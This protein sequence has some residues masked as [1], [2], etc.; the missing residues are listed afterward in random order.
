MNEGGFWDG[1]NVR[2]N[3][4]TV[5]AKS[6]RE[7]QFGVLIDA[8]VEGKTLMA[9]VAAADKRDS[10]TTAVV[11]AV[12]KF[13]T[14]SSSTASSRS[15]ESSPVRVVFRVTPD[16]TETVMGGTADFRM[17]LRNTSDMTL[18][19]LTVRMTYDATK[20]ILEDGP[21]PDRASSNWLEWDIASLVRDGSWQATVTLR[22]RDGVSGPDALTVDASIVGGGSMRIASGSRTA[23]AAVGTLGALPTTGWGLDAFAM[24]AAGAA[25][26]GLAAIQR[27]FQ[28]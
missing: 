8:N 10:D 9:G 24:A 4:M 27:K 5:D 12:K 21:V 2:W 6:S 19:D 23:G 3:K 14:S 22:A 28:R 20:V 7:M 18:D 11:A 16:R 25:C 13:K 17:D 15:A 1:R 26:I